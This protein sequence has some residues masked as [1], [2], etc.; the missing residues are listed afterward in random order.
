M[1]NHKKNVLTVLL[2]LVTTL[3]VFMGTPQIIKADPLPTVIDLST[4]TTTNMNYFDAFYS[5]YRFSATAHTLYLI[6]EN[7]IYQI[8]GTN[9]NLSIQVGET[10]MTT[11]HNATIEIKG[12]VNITGEYPLVICCNTT[13]WLDPVYNNNI[14]NAANGGNAIS[15]AKNGLILKIRGNGT[16]DLY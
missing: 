11:I 4:L 6:E 16:L 7:G 13:L 12:S 5:D 1:K 14:F 3:S 10:T 8:T 15:F 2:V 9:S